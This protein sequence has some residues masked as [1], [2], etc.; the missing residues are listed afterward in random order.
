[1]EFLGS[2]HPLVIHFP[3]VLLLLYAVLE[4][5]G[6]LLKKEE[7]I[8]GAFIILILGVVSVVAAVLTGNQAEQLAEKTISSA[9]R[10]PEEIVEKHEWFATLTVWYF[11]LI[12]ILRTYLVVKKKFVGRIRYIFIIFAVVGAVLVWS[13]AEEGGE[14]VYEHGIGTEIIK[15]PGR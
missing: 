7:V 8:R 3:I 13:T 10:F 12:L 4:I 2:L 1:M 5:T 6:I 11:V 14:L 9:F 15:L